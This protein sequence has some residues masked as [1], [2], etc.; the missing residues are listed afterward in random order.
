MIVLHLPGVGLWSGD[1]TPRCFTTRSADQFP[2]L[3]ITP[4]EFAYGL[5]Y[6]GAVGRQNRI[7][8]LF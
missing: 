1:L 7:K 2:D 6:F 3:S 4:H 5:A 8:M